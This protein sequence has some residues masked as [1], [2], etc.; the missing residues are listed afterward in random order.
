MKIFAYLVTMTA[1]AAL[2]CGG[3]TGS[4]AV[5]PEPPAGEVW[6]TSEQ[7]R[8]AR[9][10]VEPVGERDVAG[11]VLTAGTVNLDPARTGHVF[12]PVTGRVVEIVASLGDRVKKGDPLAI[13]ESPDVGSAVSDVRKAEADLIAA[14]HDFKRKKDLY[15]DNAGTASDLDM[16]EDNYRRAKTE[17]ERAQQKQALLHVGNADAVTQRFSLLAPVDGEV[18]SRDISPGVEV[19]GQYAGNSPELFTI[20]EIDRVWV[21]GQLYEMDL[22]RVGIGAAASVS[23]VAYPGKTFHGEVDW[24]SGELDPQTRTASVLAKFE[25]PDRQL[26]PMMYATMELSV[27]HRVALAVPREAILRVED[28]KIVFVES[29][30]SGNTHRFRRVQVDVDEG[31]SDSWIEVKSGLHAGDRIAVRGGILL[32]ANL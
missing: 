28:A 21:L 16:A 25:N 5:P 2:S 31:G 24:V 15:R 9:I 10:D 19:Q 26:R 11:T 20:G 8:D 12:S 17:L 4:R 23:V 3:H 7:M 30:L 14:G 29:G 13:I 22:G 32:L 1:A 18:L 6:L 27:D